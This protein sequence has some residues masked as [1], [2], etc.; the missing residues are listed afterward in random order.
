MGAIG[1]MQKYV[2]FKAARGIEAAA[3]NPGEGGGAASLGLGAGIGMMLP[4]MLAGALGQQ[5]RPGAGGPGGP[6]GGMPPVPG[7]GATV[8]CPKCQSN[9]PQGA[10][11]CG[12]CG[13]AMPVAAACPKCQASVPAGAKFCGNC[14]TA[15]AAA[16]AAAALCSKCNT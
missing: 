5:G 2:A 10:K 15:M 7:G 16:P 1:D 4:G 12:T 11:F 9:V 3:S 13:T 14:G 8:A 6:A